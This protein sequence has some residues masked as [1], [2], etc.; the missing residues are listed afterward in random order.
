MSEHGAA[1]NQ[2][3]I[4]CAADLRQVIKTVSSP[5]LR[6][7]GW[8][9]PA[10]TWSL[11]VAGGWR[12]G[13]FKVSGIGAPIRSK[14]SRWWLVAGGLGEDRPGGGGGV[15][16]ADLETGDHDPRIPCIRRRDPADLDR[17]HRVATDAANQL[18]A[19]VALPLPEMARCPE[20]DLSAVA[21]AGG[22]QLIRCRN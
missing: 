1:N 15:G 17:S 18:N 13:Y 6:R 19:K 20:V 7:A 2:Q 5:K 11:V 8:V 4:T 16:E 21:P 22:V 9:I 3:P 12:S 10:L 14:A